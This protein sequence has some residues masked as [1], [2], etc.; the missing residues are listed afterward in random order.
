MLF[1]QRITEIPHKVFLKPTVCPNNMKGPLKCSK[2]LIRLVNS[3]PVNNY[4]NRR[5]R[6]PK[7][8]RKKIQNKNQPNRKPKI[9]KYRLNNRKMQWKKEKRKSEKRLKPIHFLICAIFQISRLDAAVTYSKFI[10]IFRLC[11]CV[12]TVH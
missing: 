2:C 4:S 7:R 10:Q 5:E 12:T 8:I 1:L 3:K 9:K 11:S 6:K